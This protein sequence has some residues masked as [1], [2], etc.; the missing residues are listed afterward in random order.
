MK[1][2]V[3]LTLATGLGLSA[4]GGRDD[5]IPFDGQFYRTKLSKVDGQRAVFQVTAE[6][7]SASLE[8]AREAARY[9][10]TTYCVTEYGSSD[11]VWVIS[12]DADTSLLPIQGDTLTLQG[13][14]PE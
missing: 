4:C 14:C 2:I 11:I 8:G 13:A 10:A 1:T 3:M 7:V 5:D 6:P 9:E 12:P